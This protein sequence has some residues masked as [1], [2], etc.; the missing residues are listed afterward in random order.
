MPPVTVPSAKNPFRVD[1]EFVPAGDQPAAIEALSSGIEAGDRFQTLLG[2]TGSGKSATIAWTIEQVQ[3]I[4]RQRR[5]LLQ[6][7]WPGFDA[8]ALEEGQLVVEQ[9][10]LVAQVVGP[11]G[12]DLDLVD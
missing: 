9:E 3:R 6:Q 5:V 12:G 1:A 10:A 11:G 4:Q 2:I 7:S 8:L